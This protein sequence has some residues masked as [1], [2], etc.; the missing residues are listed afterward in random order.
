MRIVREAET[1]FGHSD[2]VAVESGIL[3]FVVNDS[4]PVVAGRQMFP[5]DCRLTLSGGDGGGSVSERLGFIFRP[6]V[7]RLKDD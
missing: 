6:S 7:T 4:N 3:I 2:E 5:H 1:F